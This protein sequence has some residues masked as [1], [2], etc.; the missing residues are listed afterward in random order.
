MTTSAGSPVFP[1]VPDVTLFTPGREPDIEREFQSVS[2][3]VT[4][5]AVLGP[6]DQD[7]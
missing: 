5:T 7:V 3:K 6:D 1:A 4:E 2:L